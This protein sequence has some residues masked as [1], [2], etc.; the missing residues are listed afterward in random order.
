MKKPKLLRLTS[1]AI[2]CGTALAMSSSAHALYTGTVLTGAQVPDWAVGNYSCSGTLITPRVVV[3]AAHCSGDTR[4]GYYHRK[5]GQVYMGKAIAYPNTYGP[6]GDVGILI[7][8]TLFGGSAATQ[9]APIASYAEEKEALRNGNDAMTTGTSLVVYGKDSNSANFMTAA[10]Y[11]DTYWEDTHK[12]LYRSVQRY[13]ELGGVDA[14]RLN[15][16]GDAI[17]NTALANLLYGP[18]PGGWGWNDRDVDDMVL[19][20]ASQFHDW[21]WSPIVSGDSGGGVF[22]RRPDGSLRLAGNVSGEFAH[23]RLSNHWPWVVKTLVTEGLRDDAILISKKVLGTDDWGSNDRLAT[24]GQIF[25]YD[26]PYNGD[27]EYYRLASLGS[28]GRYWYFPTDRR[29]NSFWEYLGTQLPNI[30]QATTPMGVWGE[31]DRHAT[32]GQVFIYNNPYTQEVEYFRANAT[33]LYWYFPI[34]KTNNT[35]WTYLGTDLPTRP[36]KF[37]E[38]IN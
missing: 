32:Q 23:S 36:M 16:L 7:T 15:G 30:E 11:T 20:T 10:R 13:R 38:R 31:N 37:V 12:L 17:F 25:V 8:D 33:G 2:A 9:T 14:Q 1:L 22:L 4:S 34:D 28:D 5:N 21:S 18:A 19:L 24:V 3:T 27:I 29:D 35:D 26:N 6:I